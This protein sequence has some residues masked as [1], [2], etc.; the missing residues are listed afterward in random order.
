MKFLMTAASLSCL[1]LMLLEISEGLVGP[2]EASRLLG[3]AR[4]TMQHE[5]QRGQ[6]E[7]M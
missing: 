4:Q 1:I 7:A 6:L 2:D 5:V 3:V